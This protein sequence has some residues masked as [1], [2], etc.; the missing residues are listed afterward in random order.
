[1]IQTRRNTKYTP[2]N[3]AEVAESANAELS[4]TS[5]LDCSTSVLV[6][7]FPSGQLRTDVV[8]ANYFFDRNQS[9]KIPISQGKCAGKDATTVRNCSPPFKNYSIF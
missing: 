7:V 3:A 5:S 8:D 6:G 9:L 4:P 2:W 1:M